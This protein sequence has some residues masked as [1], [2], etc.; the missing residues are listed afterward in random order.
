M[1]TFL[2]ILVADNPRDACVHP[3]S[4]VVRNLPKVVEASD[5]HESSGS[6]VDTFLSQVDMT[7]GME[8]F[9]PCLPRVS[10]VDED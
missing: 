6:T 7:R 5:H 1:A 3:S 9:F 2:P 10:E 8:E 4:R